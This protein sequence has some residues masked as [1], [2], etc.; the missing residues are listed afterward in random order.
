[1]NPCFLGGRIVGKTTSAAF[2]YRVG[3]PIA[4]ADLNDHEARIDG[5]RVTVNIAGVPCAGVV[6]LGP[7]FD[8]DGLRMRSGG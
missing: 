4:L 2:G 5:G 8:P 7:V 1:M 3:S 6:K